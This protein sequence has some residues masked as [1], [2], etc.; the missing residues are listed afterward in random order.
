MNGSRH[1]AA[2][3]YFFIP[4]GLQYSLGVAADSRHRL[5]RV[6][7]STAIALKDGF[8]FIEEHLMLIGRPLGALAACELRSPAPTSR[9]AFHSFN[10]KY[11]KV[12]RTWG[13]LDS[14]EYPVARSN[15][16]PLVDA[17]E[18]AS[19]YAFTYTVPQANADATF[20]ISGAAESRP[21]HS[22]L[23][24]RIVAYRD[25]SPQ[26]MAQKS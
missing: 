24:D 4:A 6:Q 26:G 10:A 23:T 3:G 18:S 17:P 11:S 22:D 9:N 19:L 7:F 15:V 14:N 5:E 21:E 12:L 2:G 25:L 20:V 1:F 8:D 13:L 16:C